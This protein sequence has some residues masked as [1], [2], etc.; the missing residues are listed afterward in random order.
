MPDTAEVARLLDILGNRNRRRII[1]LLRQKPCFVTEI[2]DTLMLSPKAVIEHLQM[3]EREAILSCQ[4]DDRRRKYYYLANDIMV[5]VSL[6]H[7][8]PVSDD[9]EGEAISAAPSGRPAAEE[10][11]LA[12]RKRAEEENGRL[13]K[14]IE[15]LARMIHAHDQLADS[16]EQLNHDIETKITDIAHNHT[17]IFRDERELSV[18]IAL[19]HESLTLEELEHVTGSS[20]EMLIPFLRRLERRGIV[21]QHEGKIQLRGVYA[22][23]G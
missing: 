10:S 20:P 22:E 1:D 8:G 3:M 9:Q 17:D 19:C 5:E 7:T 14:S 4:T 15:I 6:R 18:I 21:E 23:Q 13:K 12:A 11:G 2:S 16:L